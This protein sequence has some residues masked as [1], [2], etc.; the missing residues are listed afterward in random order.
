[1]VHFDTAG[2]AHRGVHHPARHAVRRHVHGAGARAPAGRRAHHARAA[3]GRRGR[4]GVPPRQPTHRPRRPSIARR[5]PRED[6]RVHR[7]VRHQ[8]GQRRADPGLDRRL[9]ADGLRHRRHHGGAGGDQR[10]F[11]FA[12]KFG[13]R[14]S[15][16]SSSR[17]PWF[18]A[19]ISTQ[20]STWPEAFV[21]DAP[22]VGSAPTTRSPERRR[23][24]RRG[25]GRAD[26]RWLEAHG[27]GEATITYKLRDWLFSRQRYW[28]EPFPIVYDEHGNPHALP[29]DGAA[30]GAARDRPL[31][32]PHVRPRRCDSN[33]ES[34]AGPADDWV[35][36]TLD[37]GDGPQTY[38]R[39]PT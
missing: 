29:D 28:G 33:P 7:L 26:Q 22:Y 24:G 34:A 11:E 30:G 2:R 6:R 20:P 21:G 16:P 12:R 23:H 19:R 14:S 9:R 5:R 13:L 8:P 37:L 3:G 27:H 32:S 1:M 17:P 15:S 4:R 31:L 18:D 39:E 36:S 25:Q 38:R 10:D 35:T